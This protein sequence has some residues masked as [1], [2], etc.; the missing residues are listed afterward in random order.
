MRTINKLMIVEDNMLIRLDL[1]ESLSDNG[2]TICATAR[3]GEEAITKAY[4]SKPELVLMDIGLKG[5][6]SGIEAAHILHQQTKVPIIFLSGN[7]DLKKD[8]M[9]LEINP[10]AFIVKP[11]STSHLIRIIEEQEVI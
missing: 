3:S 7:S 11:I 5:D 8:P 6:M 1:E 4:E 9:I 10:I 2:F